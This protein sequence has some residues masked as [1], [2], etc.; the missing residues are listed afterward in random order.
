MKYIL[1]FISAITLTFLANSEITSPPD[2]VVLDNQQAFNTPMRFV[3]PD[4]S[5]IP[6]VQQ[7]IEQQERDYDKYFEKINQDTMVRL[8]NQINSS[9]PESAPVVDNQALR[10]YGDSYSELIKNDFN[11]I[12]LPDEKNKM[13]RLSETLLNKQGEYSFIAKENQEKEEIMKMVLEKRRK[14]IETLER[15]KESCRNA[16]RTKTFMTEEKEVE[17]CELKCK[18]GCSNQAIS[19]L[20]K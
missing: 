20:V 2:L 8:R 7:L 17:I 4:D 12:S 6:G 3:M 11:A 16:C 1:F 14:I 10:N 15:C 19:K 18:L 5:Q 9:S 13:K